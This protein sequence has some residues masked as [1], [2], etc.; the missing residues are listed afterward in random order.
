ML[1]IGSLSLILRLPLFDRYVEGDG[2]HWKH[3]KSEIPKLEAMGITALW[4]PPPCKASS[5]VAHLAPLLI[6]RIADTS[7][8]RTLLAM[9][10]MTY[11]TWQVLPRA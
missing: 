9:T 4:L 6:A 8:F 5:K 11:G 7:I 3:L 10:Y 1:D 2:K